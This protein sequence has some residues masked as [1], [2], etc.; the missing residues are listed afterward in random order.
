MRTSGSE[1]D[2]IRAYFKMQEFGEPMH[3]EKVASERVG[4]VEHD[5]WDVHCADGRWWAVSNPLNGSQFTGCRPAVRT[6][7]AC[8]SEQARAMASLV[9][10]RRERSPRQAH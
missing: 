2:E 9:G 5:I 3:L 6:C 7:C 10:G 4:G 8:D 1:R